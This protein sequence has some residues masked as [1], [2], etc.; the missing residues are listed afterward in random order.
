[1]CVRGIDYSI[2]FRNCSDT[3]VFFSFYYVP[4]HLRLVTLIDN[5]PTSPGCVCDH[6]ESTY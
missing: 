4:L 3:V 5:C 6:E 2:E 1:M